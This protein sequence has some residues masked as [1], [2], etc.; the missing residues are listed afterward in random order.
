MQKIDLMIQ[1]FFTQEPRKNSSELIQLDEV[2]FVVKFL[3]KD[4]AAGSFL[5]WFI[6]ASVSVFACG[7]D[8]ENSKIVIV[9][10]IAFFFSRLWLK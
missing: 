4:G 9:L 5:F 10:G 3:E 8:P 2:D 6:F 1:K 7:Y